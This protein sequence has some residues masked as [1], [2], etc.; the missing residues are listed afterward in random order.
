MLTYLM[1][2]IPPML[3]AMWAQWRVKSAYATGLKMPAASGLSGAET[4]DMILKAHN[5]NDVRIEPVQGY[6]SDHYDPKSKTLR[7]SPDNYSGHSVAALGIA[8]HEAGHAVQHA[9]GYAP[10]VIRNGIV[11]LTAVAPFGIFLMIG[12]MIMGGAAGAAKGGMGEIGYWLIIAGIAAFGI[13]ALFQLINLPVEFDASNRAKK[14]LASANLVQPGA[15][16]TAMNNVLNAA[17]W[18]YVAATLGAVMTVLYYLLQSG[19]LGGRRNE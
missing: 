5:I 18:T 11:P 9:V 17:A 4:A 12:G 14:L 6:L 10:L 2:F 7:L 1:F 8:A 3:L 13:I 15:E 19:L 16:A